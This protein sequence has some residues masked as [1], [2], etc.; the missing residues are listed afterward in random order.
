MNENVVANVISIDLLLNVSWK[1]QQSGTL[2]SETDLS[3]AQPWFNPEV[4]N[5]NW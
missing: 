4:Q 3:F 2:R 1:G 5:T